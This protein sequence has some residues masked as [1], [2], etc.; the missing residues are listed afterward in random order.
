MTMNLLNKILYLF[1][2]KHS[3]EFIAQQLRKP[4][5][6]FAIKV[7]SQMNQANEFLYDLVL[8]S[9]SLKENESILE[10]GF[11]NGKFF[12]KIFSKAKDL[13]I[14]GID[15]SKEMVEAAKAI[16]SEEILQVKLHLITG[17]SNNL[18]FAYHS[19]DKVFCNNVIYFWDD[20]VE[21]L[22]EIHRVLKPKGKF[23]TGIRNKDT[24][25]QF[26]FTKYD[27]N[28]YE[29]EEWVEILERNGF[30]VIKINKKADPTG[31]YEGSKINME[32]VCIIAEKTDKF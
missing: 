27:F 11:G 28:L 12:K 2:S 17:N 5:G 9:M 18:P 7:A 31:I 3:P 23:Y 32:S 22:T 24:L 1:Q 16:N 8:E 13:N 30:L 19:F 6:N 10:I 26:P 25:Q 4:G 29:T 15:Y 20:P 21:H 14:S